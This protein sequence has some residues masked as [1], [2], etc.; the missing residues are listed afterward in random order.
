MFLFW[1]VHFLKELLALLYFR[2]RTLSLNGPALGDLIPKRF[3]LLY[4]T[5][6]TSP[7]NIL[8]T[9]KKNLLIS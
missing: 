5:L 9:P 3:T 8:P 4:F 6:L 2:R 7:Q 1:G